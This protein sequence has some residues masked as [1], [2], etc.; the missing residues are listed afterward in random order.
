MRTYRKTLRLFGALLCGAALVGAVYTAHADWDPGQPAKWVQ[1]P[2]LT[3]NGLDVLASHINATPLQYNKILA[4]DFLCTGSGLI[5]DI[6]IWGSWWDDIEVDP[7]RLQ[8]HLS[9]H[10]DIPASANPDGFSKPGQQLWSITMAPTSARFYAQAQEQFFDPNQNAIIGIDS[11]VWQYNF[12]I[13]EQVAFPQ[14]RGTIYWLDAQALVPTEQPGTPQPL[15]GW[16]TSQDHWNDDAVFG[17]SIEFSQGGI[18]DWKPLLHPLTGETLDLAFVI[19]P[20]PQTYAVVAGLGLLGF[21]LIRRV[22]SRR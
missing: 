7:A 10:A 8:F 6:H 15:W 2:D 1:L 14:E 13:P 12:I 22:R 11:L 19:T 5:T 3:P 20:E 18:G 4:D 17:H 9:L 16:K 21:A